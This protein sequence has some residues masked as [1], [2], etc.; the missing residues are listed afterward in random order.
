MSPSPLTPGAVRVENVWKRFRVDA[1]RH[2]F[3][4][5]ES[6]RL[7]AGLRGDAATGWRWV[8]RDISFDL[9]PGESLGLIGVNGSGKSTLLKM[10]A[11]VVHP[12]SGVAETA[13][14]IGSVMDV[15]AAVQS[16]LSGRENIV[17]YGRMQG[18]SYRQIRQRTDAILEFAGLT[19]AADRLVKHYSS[20]MNVRL[21]FALASHVE[22]SILVVDEALA[23][24]DADFKRRSLQRMREIV[25]AGATLLFVSHG[26]EQLQ[27]MCRRALWLDAGEV[28][29]D[30]DSSVV[31]GL[32][33]ESLDDS[34]A[35]TGELVSV[36]SDLAAV[37][38]VIEPG[39]TLQFTV[40]IES[41]ETRTA[42]LTVGLGLGEIDPFVTAHHRIDLAAGSTSFVV[43]LRDLSVA[44]GS[45]Q[46]LAAVTEPGGA[47]LS[48]WG[49][50]GRMRVRGH[51]PA[52]LPT[53]VARTSPF[54]ID[55][56]I[57]VVP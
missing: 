45:F 10:I 46:V 36:R 43:S 19:D 9:Q 41:D 20:G 39:G 7:L 37:P 34:R 54:V 23:V 16:S 3:G 38:R 15:G 48:G 53:G 42:D 12:T 47:S 11:G 51:A 5:D 30:G 52:P 8:L 33:R 50:I 29:A 49:P 4:A 21:G 31:V 28:R 57:E 2:R 14:T 56:A 27:S 25:D 40:T 13:G 22:P 17:L 44:A 26:L 24:G 32:Y 35:L 18:W 1:V 6:R 55:S